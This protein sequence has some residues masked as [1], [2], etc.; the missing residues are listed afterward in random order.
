MGMPTSP[1]WEFDPEQM[2]KNK[3]GRGNPHKRLPRGHTLLRMDPETWDRATL[4][5]LP[6]EERERDSTA[7]DLSETSQSPRFWV[8]KR[9]SRKQLKVSLLKQ[10]LQEDLET[11]KKSY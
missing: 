3:P 10:T 11:R 5:T 6:G 9:G 8:T 1:E 4:G 2:G 7:T